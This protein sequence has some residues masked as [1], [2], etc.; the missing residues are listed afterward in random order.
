MSFLKSLENATSLTRTENGAVARNTTK[1]YL[2]DLFAQIGAMRTRNDRDI[3]EAFSRAYYEDE[4]LAMKMLFY[5]RDIRGGQGERRT[6]RIILKYLAKNKP[7]VLRKNIHLI[8]YYGRWD[9]ILSLFGTPLEVDALELIQK[10]LKEDWESDS[11]SLLAKWLPS[12]NTSSKKTRNNARVIQEFFDLT[13]RDYRKMVTK[14][15]KKIN[16]VETKMSAKEWRAIEY[17]KLPSKAGLQYRKAFMKRDEFR[18]QAFLDSLS[19]GERKVNAS[20]LY[21]YEI[22]EKCHKWNLDLNEITLFDEMWKALPDYIGEKQEDSIAVVDVSG[23]MSG[24]P[25]DVALSVGMY[26][27]ERNK[28]RFKDYFLTFSQRPQLVKIHGK[29]VVDK[30]INMKKAHWEMNT[31]IEA[32]FD[33]ILNTALKDNYSQDEIPKKLYI[34]SDMEFDAATSSGGYWGHSRTSRVEKTLFEKIES[35][36]NQAGY[37]MPQL[38]FW[39][40][41]ARNEQFPIQMDRRGFQMVSGCSPSIFEST[42]SGEIRTAYDLMLDILNKERYDLV[43][44]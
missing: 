29:T 33:L 11:P 18:Y 32:V 15:R 16:I 36:Y 35:K 4:L 6:S 40:V 34:I 20:T 42:M 21:P 5:A 17:D 37:S 1:S 10:Q 3:I 23:S 8:P 41:N 22:V 12:N 43:T 44:I 38:V 9:D 14:L 13:E 2:V 27:A 25:L 30:V 28:G 31:N 19:K 24:R 7:N 26:L 39:N